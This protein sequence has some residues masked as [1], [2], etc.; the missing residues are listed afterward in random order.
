MKKHMMEAQTS[1]EGGVVAGLA[2]AEPVACADDFEIFNM[3]VESDLAPEERDAYDWRRSAN[4][5]DNEADVA[6]LDSIED[7]HHTREA[8]FDNTNLSGD[9]ISD[10]LF[11]LTTEQ[12]FLYRRQIGWYDLELCI[13]QYEYHINDLRKQG[14]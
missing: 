2:M 14:R 6:V 12:G 10:A 9:Q 13:G 4:I 8:I 5:S 1:T 7:G 3:L 11:R